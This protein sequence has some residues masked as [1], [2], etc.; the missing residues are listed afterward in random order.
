MMVQVEHCTLIRT[1]YFKHRQTVA[2]ACVQL[3]RVENGV[4]M[5]RCS[6]VQP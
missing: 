1:I 2:A 4:L 6:C 3:N 5:T